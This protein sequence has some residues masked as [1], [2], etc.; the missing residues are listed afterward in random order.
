MN[1]CIVKNHWKIGFDYM[2][3]LDI[4]IFSIVSLIFEAKLNKF[5]PN[6]FVSCLNSLTTSHVVPVKY[7]KSKNGLDT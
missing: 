7:E 5:S 2:L 1:L 3:E 4:L 6:F